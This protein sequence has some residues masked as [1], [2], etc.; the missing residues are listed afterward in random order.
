MP[1]KRP[2]SEPNS[3]CLHEISRL[4]KRLQRRRTESLY[5]LL[6]DDYDQFI[7]CEE[8]SKG[9]SCWVNGFPETVY[10]LAKKRGSSSIILVHN[11]P[12]GNPDPGFQDL[13]ACG[14]PEKDS[15]AYGIELADCVIIGRDGYY[16]FRHGRKDY[17]YKTAKKDNDY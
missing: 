8:V 12:S 2:P 7:G 10:G 4:Y 13:V 9:G 3:E 15:E 16:S 6:Y 17:P 14:S 11:H 1:L 5:A